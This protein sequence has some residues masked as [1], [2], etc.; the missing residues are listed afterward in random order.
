[1]S[2]LQI[3]TK[4]P[5]VFFLRRG[6]YIPLIVGWLVM[7]MMLAAI[8]EGRLAPWDTTRFRPAV[9][10]WERTV[11][12]FFEGGIGST[13]PASAVIALSMLMYGWAHGRSAANRPALT[14][15]FAICNILFIAITSQAVGWAT[16]WNDSLLPQPRP[17]L[18]VG[19][20]RNLPAIVV[21]AG[22]ALLLLLSHWTIAVAVQRPNRN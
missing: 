10:T 20:Q 17:L 13:L 3:T 12:D 16:A 21:T 14:W 22:L 9:G 11:N 6:G 7:W 8:T 18:D 4:N 2:S 19:Y 1:M 15:A 5:T